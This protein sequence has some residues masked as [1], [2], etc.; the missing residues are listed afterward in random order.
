MLGCFAVFWLRSII[1]H[2]GLGNDMDSAWQA[3]LRIRSGANVYSPDPTA[4]YSYAPWF[5]WLWVPLTYLPPR[6]VFGAWLGLCVA[7][8]YLSLRWSHPSLGAVLLIAPLTFY[9]AWVGNVQPLM[10]AAL[11]AG[12]PRR[13]GPLA[14]GAAASLKVVPI[15]LVLHWAGNREWWKVVF[16]LVCAAALGAP[17]LLYGLDQYPRGL[18][19]QLS[20]RAVSPE[21]WIAV[22][23]VATLIALR[24]ARTR[25]SRLASAVAVIAARPALITYDVGYLLTAL[26]PIR[27]SE[28]AR[29]KGS[30]RTVTRA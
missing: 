2:G 6:V 26:V 11:V 28:P 19:G 18:P 4:G 1:I 10:I 27:Q 30:G 22:A 5:A 23:L 29:S 3:A 13:W 21:V 15:L 17:A 24:S 12:I 16:A 8:W 7:A 25:Y 20:L 14:V 9:A